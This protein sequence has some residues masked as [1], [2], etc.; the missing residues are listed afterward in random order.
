MLER[1]SSGD[2]VL[3]P[4]PVLIFLNVKRCL[5]KETDAAGMVKMHVGYDNMPNFIRL[6]VYASKNFNGVDVSLKLSFAGQGLPPLRR[7]MKEAALELS[8]Y[9]SFAGFALHSYE[10][11][12]PFLASSPPSRPA[13]DR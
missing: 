13:G 9:R 4:E 5:G 12:G 7:A 3:Q 11:L 6:D 10:S 1:R 2:R 8:G